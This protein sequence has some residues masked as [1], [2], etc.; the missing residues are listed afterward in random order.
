MNTV[1]G[2]SPRVSTKLA[3]NGI[4]ALGLVCAALSCLMLLQGERA[5]A[6]LLVLAALVLD[7]VDGPIARKMGVSSRLGSGLDS[8]A[9]V[10]IYLLFPAIFWASEYAL[11]LWVLAIFVGAGAFRLVRFTLIGFGSDGGKLLYAGM[12]VFYSQFLLAFT[13]LFHFDGILLSVV[14]L[15]MSVLMISTL[16]FAKISVRV[17][18]AALVIYAAILALELSGVL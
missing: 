17:L 16:P 11:P 2:H 12:P 8:C 5:L 10:L 14:L 15:A 9:D 13:L 7:M 4:T 3:V 18:S 1:A 6:F